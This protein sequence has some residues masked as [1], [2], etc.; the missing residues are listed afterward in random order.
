VSCRY[1]LE[2]TTSTKGGQWPDHGHE[3]WDWAV[4]DVIDVRVG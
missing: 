3:I 4:D 1:E 2:L